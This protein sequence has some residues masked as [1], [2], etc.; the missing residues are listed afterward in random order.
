MLGT[1]KAIKLWGFIQSHRTNE[2]TDK[3]TVASMLGVLWAT[4]QL[5]P[6]RA[7]PSL[8]LITLPPHLNRI[9]TMASSLLLPRLLQA[10]AFNQPGLGIPLS[11]PI[12]ALQ[13]EIKRIAL[14]TETR[15]FK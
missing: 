2:L 5:L 1:T 9:P 4:S 7:D 15:T 13:I 12:L 11:F 8:I 3:T 14:V 6:M 10:W